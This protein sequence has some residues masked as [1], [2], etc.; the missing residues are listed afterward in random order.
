MMM[1][2]LSMTTGA[3]R[4]T[5]PDP[6]AMPIVSVETKAKAPAVKKVAAKD[7]KKPKK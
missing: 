6:P 4:I 5:S 1:L 3:L 7:T 2:S